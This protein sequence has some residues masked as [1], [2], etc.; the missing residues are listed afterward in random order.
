MRGGKN[1]VENFDA[2]G[3]T[4]PKDVVARMQFIYRIKLINLIVQDEVQ[5]KV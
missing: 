1:G 4:L 5:L 2:V 3:K